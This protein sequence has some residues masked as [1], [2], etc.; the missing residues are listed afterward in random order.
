MDI[1]KII[2]EEVESFKDD[3]KTLNPNTYKVYHGTN[4]EFD[5]FD[6]SRATQGIIWF[7]DSIDSIKKGEH[8]GLGN[9]YIMT[10]YITLNNPAGWEEYDKLGLQQIE[11]RGYDGVILPHGTEYNDYIV[12][13]TKSI[14]KTP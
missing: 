14:S 9:K 2:Q 12:F 13:D 4:Q 1:N 11:D 6:L 10:R 7:T 8:G 3:Q 5:N